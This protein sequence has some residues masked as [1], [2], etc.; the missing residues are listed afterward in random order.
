MEAPLKTK[1]EQALRMK[2]SHTKRC[3]HRPI[4]QKISPHQPT[5]GL[6]EFRPQNNKLP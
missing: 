4:E 3:H 6:E 1:N 5:N 2:R